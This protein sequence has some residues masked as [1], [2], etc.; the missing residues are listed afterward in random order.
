MTKTF[1]L[2]AY[3]DNCFKPSKPMT[4]KEALAALKERFPVNKHDVLIEKDDKFIIKPI[5]TAHQFVCKTPEHPIVYLTTHEIDHE[6]ES[7]DSFYCPTC[8]AYWQEP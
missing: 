5:E 6:I 3:G 4:R 8:N 7:L 1:T 2:I